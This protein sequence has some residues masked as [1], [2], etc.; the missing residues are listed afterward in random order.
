MHNYIS[1]ETPIVATSI[2]STVPQS[3][4]TAVAVGNVPPAVEFKHAGVSAH[5]IHSSLTTEGKEFDS[6]SLSATVINI[7]SFLSKTF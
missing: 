1:S 3:T 4:V 7:T 5:R 6:E 2:A